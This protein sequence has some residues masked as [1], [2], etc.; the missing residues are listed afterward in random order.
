M[1]PIPDELL[2]G[3]FHR[4]QALTAGVTARV[5]E[6]S[7]FVRVLPCVYRHR[8]HEM[9]D[10]DWLTAARLTLP[11]TA[12]LTG[13]SRIQELGLDLGPRYPLHFVV[14]G[15]LHLVLDRIFLHRTVELA[16]NDGAGVTPEAAFLAYCR[17]ARFIDAIKVGDWLLRHG[18]ATVDS[19][20]ALALA[21]PWRDG[22][23]ESLLVL[24]HLDGRSRSLRE[25]EMRALL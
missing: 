5:L 12:L 16:P 7:R 11:A 23:R 6:G 9:S 21:Q 1:R 14:E 20:G 19:I 24:D 13:I 25:S 18:H 15:D 3:P 22:V 8:D 2:A 10:D 17:W 4:R